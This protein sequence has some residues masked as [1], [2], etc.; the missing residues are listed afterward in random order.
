MRTWLKDL[1][2]QSGKTMK[3]VADSAGISESFYSQIEN[4]IRNASVSVAKKI[5]EILGFNWQKFFE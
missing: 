2:I 3:N 4:G 5:A 1:R